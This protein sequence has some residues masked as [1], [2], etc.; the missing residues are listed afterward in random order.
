MHGKALLLYGDT[1][2]IPAWLDPCKGCWYLCEGGKV[3]RELPP[4]FFHHWKEVQKYT[5][6]S[7]DTVVIPGE[8]THLAVATMQSYIVALYMMYPLLLLH[9]KTVNTAST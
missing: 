8:R 4:H 2:I 9:G 5:H 6:P 3:L 1:I 7:F